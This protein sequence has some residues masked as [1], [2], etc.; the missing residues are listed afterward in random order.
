ME[1]ICVFVLGCGFKKKK[2][3]D[4]WLIASIS[5]VGLTSFVFLL[6]LS[7]SFFRG[8]DF[9]DEG[10]YLYYYTHAQEP[11]FLPIDNILGQIG[12]IFGN[13]IVVWR[14]VGL[15]ILFLSAMFF[16]RTVSALRTFT[17]IFTLGS[18]LAISVSRLTVLSSEQLS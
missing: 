17:I 5:L 10:F 15:V 2:T 1:S 4:H 8:F 9:T 3:I 14:F 6:L 11:G 7:F 18:F 12:F 13:N 16:A